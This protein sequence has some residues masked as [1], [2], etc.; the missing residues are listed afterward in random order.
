MSPSAPSARPRLDPHDPAAIDTLLSEEELAVRQT[1]RDF[2]ADKILPHVAEWYEKG[3]LPGIRELTS[4]LG[5]IGL[6]GH[7]RDL[8][9]RQ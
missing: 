6:P 2:C 4:E 3:E 8:A 1:V 9:V 7:V 5:K